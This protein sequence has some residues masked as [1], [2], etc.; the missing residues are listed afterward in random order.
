MWEPDTV[1][2]TFNINL[3][4]GVSATTSGFTK[5]TTVALTI[6]STQNIYTGDYELT[7]VGYEHKG[8]ATQASATTPTYTTSFTV[9]NSA[10]TLYAVWQKKS[11]TVAY[12]TNGGTLGTSGFTA[13]NAT[14]QYGET[15]DLP[16]ADQ[17]TR[18]GYTLT[19]WRASVANASGTTFFTAGTNYVVPDATGTITFTA[20]WTERTTV[21]TFH[22]NNNPGSDYTT[23]LSGKYNASIASDFPTPTAMTGY[24]FTGWYVMSGNGYV[25]YTKPATFPE[26]DVVLYAGWSMD[27]LSAEIQRFPSDIDNTG[28]Y[29]STG[30]TKYWYQEPGRTN[31]KTEFVQANDVFDAT[32]GVLYDYTKITETN[33]ATTELRTAID[34]LVDEPADYTAVNVFLEYYDQI[35]D[36]THYL[37]GDH[38]YAGQGPVGPNSFTTD[39]FA[40]F[41]EATD[42]FETLGLRDQETVNGYASTLETTYNNLVPTSADYSQFE[43]YLNE[44]LTLNTIIGTEDTSLEEFFGD[45]WGLLWYEEGSWYA[46]FEYAMIYNYDL[47]RDLNIF[48]QSTVDSAVADLQSL[49]ESMIPNPPDFSEYYAN[50]CEDRAIDIYN[51]SDWYQDAYRE[52]VW[53]A[54]DV[55]DTATR[56]GELT[57]RYDQPMVDEIIGSLV[58]LLNDPKYKSYQLIF[59]MNDGT[60]AEVG[61]ETVECIASIKGLAPANPEREGYVFL[62]WYTTREDTADEVG[63]KIDFT[64]DIEMGTA[65]RILF[66]RWEKERAAYTLDVS[67]TYSNVYLKFDDGAESLQGNKYTNDEVLYGTKVTLRA[68]PDGDNRVFLYWKDVGNSGTRSRIVSYDEVLEFT[69]EADWYLTAVYSE[70]EGS[71]YYSV[72]FVDSIL[73]TIIKE[74]KVAT[75]TS[76]TAPEIAATH[77]EYTFTGWNKTFDSVTENM[78]ITSVYE[79]TEELFTIT[80][81]IGEETTESTYRYNAPVTLTIADE[82]IPDSKVFAG[83]SLNG[84]DIVSYDRTYKFYAYKDMTVTAIF[85]DEAVKAE[86]TVT[87]ETTIKEQTETTYKAEFMVTREVPEDYVFVSSGLLLTQSAD[88]GTNENLTFETQ[89]E[90]TSAIRLYRTVHTDN[91]GQYQL[92]VKTSS[93]KTFYAR[94]FVVYLDTASGELVTLYTDVVTTQATN[95]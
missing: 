52:S 36:E 44:A 93:G 43:W 85:A 62:G 50:N 82:D 16:N 79:L 65:D 18:A 88:L 80:T 3:P 38:P 54:Y 11:I 56:N 57:Y 46:F 24:S 78:I 95:G 53:A 66:A 64:K 35:I 20:E 67:T 61:R 83:W 87:L 30:E 9:P 76:A 86:P 28:V 22:H 89:T 71:G 51:S 27:A 74:E 81:I 72:V 47:P 1:N 14:V 55:V 34:A 42:I 32:N 70:A 6:G 7:A 69:L 39:S 4:L 84:K 41:E 15:V 59:M 29:P 68:V 77:G 49:Y 5:N 60:D 19:G 17:I 21:Y 92:T 75:G 45:T 23:T 58:E 31:A 37:Q 33:T 12:T 13:N 8:W 40:D 73:K 25:P 10:Q 90:N 94:G 91:D 26:D 2:V 48:E 63:E